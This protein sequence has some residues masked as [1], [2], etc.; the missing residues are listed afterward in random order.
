MRDPIKY[1]IYISD[2][3]IDMFYSEIPKGLLKSIASELNLNLSLLGSSIGATMKNSPSEETRY[4]KLKLVTKYIEKHRAVGTVDT[5]A[6]YFKGKLDMDWGF[7]SWRKG[8]DPEIV[9]FRGETENTRIMLTGS[10]Q[11]IVGSQ[12]AGEVSPIF[13]RIGSLSIVGWKLLVAAHKEDLH[14][15]NLDQ[16]IDLADK[17]VLPPAKSLQ[18]GID[19]SWSV[20]RDSDSQPGWPKQRFEFLARKLVQG[21]PESPG[22]KQSLLLLGTPLYVALS[23]D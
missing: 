21:K 10:P 14:P 2:A 16:S 7:V 6:A 13:G 9:V 5:P 23:D 1:Y 3:K 17:L 20:G 11:H 8:V 19:L 12:Q 4:S 15:A 18:H 22:T